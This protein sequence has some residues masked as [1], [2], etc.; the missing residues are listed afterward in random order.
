MGVSVPVK[1]ARAVGGCIA[2]L[3]ASACSGA[4]LSEATR[5]EMRAAPAA[6]QPALADGAVTFEEYEAATQALVECI[7]AGGFPATATLGDPPRPDLPSA[8]SVS[9]E[10]GPD[11]SAEAEANRVYD[12][13]LVEHQSIV[14]A[15]YEESH[16][17]GCPG[18][19]LSRVLRSCDAP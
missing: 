12:A 3:V 14:G 16:T 8:F 9:V 4:A 15:V 17:G 13:C 10:V 5:A 11:L 1:M 6:Q 18:G 7:E 2:L 19:P